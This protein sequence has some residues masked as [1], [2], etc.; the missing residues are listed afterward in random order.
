VDGIRFDALTKALGFISSMDRRQSVRTVLGGTIGIA[1]ASSL[2]Q[3]DAKKKKK[4]K[5]KKCKAPKKKCGKQCL[6]VLT[7]RSNCGSCGNDCEGQLCLNGSCGCP[8][9]EHF[10]ANLG[11]CARCCN[12]EECEDGLACNDAGFCDCPAG[13]HA[14]HDL[15]G[16]GEFICCNVGE[17]CEQGECLAT[18]PSEA[19]QTCNS[20]GATCGL[21]EQ[22]QPACQCVHSVDGVTRCNFAPYLDCAACEHDDDCLE[23]LGEPGLCLTNQGCCGVSPTSCVPIGDCVIPG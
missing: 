8:E 4:K 11:H 20:G 7:D 23:I 14:C 12:D 19:P 9:G 3:A 6:D 22:T 13:Q 5:K 2:Q 16:S 18:C 17:P 1:A 15:S 21:V 10:C